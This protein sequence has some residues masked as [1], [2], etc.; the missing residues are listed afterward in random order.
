MTSPAAAPAAT[1]LKLDCPPCK[2]AGGSLV[3][4]DG[5]GAALLLL[6]LLACCTPSAIA[7]SQTMPKRVHTR[8]LCPV[9]KPSHSCTG[10]NLCTLQTDS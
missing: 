10:T 6:L 2:L 7:I 8:V 3:L 1:D 9:R 5:A 4:L